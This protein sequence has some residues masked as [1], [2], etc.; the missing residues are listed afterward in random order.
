MHM[1]GGR[2]DRSQLLER[3]HYKEMLP[4]LHF[5][6]RE[7]AAES[8]QHLRLRTLLWQSLELEF[9]GRASVG[10][11]QFVY[12]HGGAPDRCV[13]PDVFVKL[14]VALRDFSCW[15]T[16]EQGGVPELAVEITSRSDRPDKP[17]S[18]K[19]EAYGEL[20]VIEL[21]RFDALATTYEAL[22]VW[23]RVDDN[24]LERVGARAEWSEALGLWWVVLPD[25]SLGRVLRLARDPV[26]QDLLLTP[27]ERD[28]RAREA[29]E[30][31]REAAEQRV[32]ELEAELGRRGG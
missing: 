14:G 6:E 8:K 23:D 32:Q 3:H 7:V 2:R 12:W 26:G 9:A 1:L 20:G 10:S 28:A 5:P 22:R 31:A 16:W 24:L 29:A 21:V 11:E 18:E 25:P 27:E 30:R 4:P 15:K 13:A 19:L 17:W